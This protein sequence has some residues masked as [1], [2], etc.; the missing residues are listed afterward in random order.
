MR[1]RSAWV[2]ITGI[3]IAATLLATAATSHESIVA[4][5]DE[6]PIEVVSVLGPVSPSG[7]GWAAVKLTLRNAGIEP[8]V[9]LTATLEVLSV[10]GTPFDFSLDNVTPSSPLQPGKSASSTLVL[11]GGGFSSNESYPLVINATLQSGSDSVYRARANCGTSAGTWLGLGDYNRC[12]TRTRYSGHTDSKTTESEGVTLLV[13]SPD[14]S[15]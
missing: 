14:V 6:R 2:T 4:S 3:L 10:F 13:T 8:V 7:S 1:R 12:H 15:L 9:S 5:Q 11:I